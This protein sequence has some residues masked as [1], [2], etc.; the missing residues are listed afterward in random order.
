MAARTAAG[1]V[2]VMR[3]M[4]VEADR[5]VEADRSAAAPVARLGVYRRWIERMIERDRPGWYRVGGRVVQG[6]KGYPAQ[7]RARGGLTTR[8][9]ITPR[10]ADK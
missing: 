7:P 1:T 8:S 3:L 10:S 9:P 5:T 6:S 2:G 4:A